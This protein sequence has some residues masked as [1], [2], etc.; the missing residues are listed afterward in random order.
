[1]GI[2]NFILR[3]VP[4]AAFLFSCNGHATPIIAGPG[5]SADAKHNDV[6]FGSISTNKSEPDSDEMQ[7]LAHALPWIFESSSIGAPLGKYYRPFA[8]L[9]ELYPPFGFS[10]EDGGLEKFIMWEDSN[11]Q[12]DIVIPVNLLGF[13]IDDVE[14]AEFFATLG[15]ETLG[16]DIGDWP[17]IIENS[18]MPGQ[19][20]A[21]PL[22]DGPAVARPGQ[23]K[24]CLQ[25]QREF[26]RK[27]EL[28]DDDCFDAVG[29]AGFNNNIGR[30]RISAIMHSSNDS[31]NSRNNPG[32]GG[33]GGGSGAGSGGAGGG[34]TSPGT[35]A[36]GGNGGNG[37]GSGG[38]PD[39]G[40]GGGE[41][42][43]GD[44][45][46]RPVPEPATPALLLLGLACVYYTRNRIRGG[47]EKQS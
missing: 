42:G 38:P 39:T 7:A 28:H 32:P 29:F 21:A 34:G 23:R 9:H 26:S 18:P 24:E 44:S 45:E 19:H 30:N 3:L 27:S 17:M 14:I 5:H 6:R 25:R 10:M 15:I 8:F 33:D 36:G 16:I 43:T 31:P 46:V 13:E 4:L 41:G 47:V 11:P 12:N 1:M 35:S 22:P 40:T 2:K 20:D 37:S